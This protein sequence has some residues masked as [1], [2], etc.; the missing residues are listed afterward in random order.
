MDFVENSVRRNE[1]Y[2][3]YGSE[4][5]IAYSKEFSFALDT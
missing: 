5:S 1:L 2:Q 3:A 4:H